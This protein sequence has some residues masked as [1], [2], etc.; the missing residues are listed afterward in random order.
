MAISTVNVSSPANEIVYQD[1]VAANAVNSIK[2]SSAKVY[3]IV[4]DNSLNV[5]ASYLKLFNLA[6]ASVSLGT[7]SPDL[8]AY[9]PAG[10]VVTMPFYTGAAIGL[11]FGTALSYAVV[12]TGGTAGTTSPS[13][14]VTLTVSYT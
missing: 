2:A 10:V 3:Y 7:T 8:V 13:S 9:V 5:A 4:I 11:T 1:T 12:T 14:A 6:S